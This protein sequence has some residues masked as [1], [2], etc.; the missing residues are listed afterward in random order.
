MGARCLSGVGQEAF[1]AISLSVVPEIYFVHQRNRRVAAFILLFSTGVYLSVPIATQVYVSSGDRRREFWALAIL[2]G[3]MLVLFV[4]FFTETAYKRFHVDPL[5]HQSEKFVLEHVNDPSLHRETEKEA[6]VTA[7]RTNME[8]LN[9]A[10][11]EQPYSFL[12]DEII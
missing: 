10:A 9:T 7:E 12:K 4:L 6:A 5:T 1:E 2:E 8:R 3:I 11:Q